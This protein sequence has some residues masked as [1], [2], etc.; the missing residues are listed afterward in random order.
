LSLAIAP[1]QK[2]NFGPIYGSI[3]FQ[4]KRFNVVFLTFLQYRQQFFGKFMSEGAL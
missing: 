3:S 2:P 4:E 1:L